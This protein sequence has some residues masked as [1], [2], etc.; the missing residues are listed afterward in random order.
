MLWYAQLIC[1]FIDIQDYEKVVKSKHCLPEKPCTV[2][3]HSTEHTSRIHWW[4]LF[5]NMPLTL[6]K[7]Y[8]KFI[9]KGILHDV[10]PLKILSLV[11]GVSGS[12]Y[13]F[14]NGPYDPLTILL[15]AVNSLGL[16]LIDNC[17]S[18]W[19]LTVANVISDWVTQNREI[20]VT[21][22]C[23]RSVTLTTTRTEQKP[24]LAGVNDTGE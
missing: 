8:M 20:Y 22:Q 3:L 12:R 7:C 14:N 9:R 19:W 15:L 5:I 13:T 10:F 21:H 23:H 4:K 16:T 2:S 17:L 11:C 24:R 1:S 6:W 18:E